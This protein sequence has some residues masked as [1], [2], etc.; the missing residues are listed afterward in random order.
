MELLPFSGHRA[1]RRSFSWAVVSLFR[2]GLKMAGPGHSGSVPVFCG[3]KRNSGQLTR[4]VGLRF[5][6]RPS[7][8]STGTGVFEQG[9]GDRARFLNLVLMLGARVVS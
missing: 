3:R 8:P 1:S 5:F 7:Q 6:T 9:N 2:S 4:A